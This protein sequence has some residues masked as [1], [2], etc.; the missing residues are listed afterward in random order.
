MSPSQPTEPTESVEPADSVDTAETPRPA[1]PSPAAIAARVRR[2]VKV[3]ALKGIDPEV[4]ASASAFGAVEGDVVVVVDGDAHYEVGPARGSAPLVP[5]VKKYLEHLAALDRFGAR[6]EV[7]AP[8]LRD[9]DASLA[10]GH[11]VLAKPDCVGD[12]GAFRARLDAASEAATGVRERLLL[13]RE[14]AKAAATAERE[15]LVLRAEAIAAKEIG[16]INWKVDAAE[17]KELLDAW[18]GAQQSAIHIGKDVERDLWQRFAHARSTFEKVRKHHFA[19]LDRVNTL[20]AGRKEELA[21][22][23]ETLAK[24]NKWEETTREFRDLMAEWKTAGRGRK[25]VDDAMWTRFQTAQD[26]FFT[27]KRT[28]LESERSVEEA[29]LATKEAILKEAEGLLPIRDLSAAKA[30]LHGIQDRFEAAGRVPKSELAH[31]TKRLSAVE[32]AIRE[33]DAAA[34]TRRNPEVEARVSGAAQQLVSAIADLN[35]QIAAATAKGDKRAMKEL[36]E[37]RDARQ[38]WLDQIQSTAS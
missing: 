8:T 5:Y 26:A 6:L 32:H 20:V 13:E 2:P 33:A 11:A 16:A 7:G 27:A 10:A 35:Q 4:F 36:T 18:K 24:S 37:S 25:S 17:L 29:N 19:E 15:A 22:R 21:L 30:A 9:I 34:W 38:A 31:L 28:A 3:P 23:A 1:A 14:E 12:L